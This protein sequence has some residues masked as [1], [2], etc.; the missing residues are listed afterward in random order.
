MET[1]VIPKGTIEKAKDSDAGAIAEIFEHYYAKIY[2]GLYY[3]VRTAQDAEDLTSEVFMKVVRSIQRQ[4]GNF[5]AWLHMI[6]KNTLTDYYRRKAS[7]KE[8]SADEKELEAVPDNTQ[9]AGSC[10]TQ[11]E[12]KTAINKL[13]GEQQEVIVLRFIEGHDNE[14]TA[15][16]TGKSV[17]AVKA[18]QFRG[19]AALKEILKEDCRL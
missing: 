3:R 11:E 18:L 15:R 17:G 8:Y 19:L 7:R 14:E 5:E 13:T 9:R 2:R 1:P 6:A 12:L 4:S 10:F 16:I